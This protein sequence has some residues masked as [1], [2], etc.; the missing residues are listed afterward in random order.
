MVEHLVC[1]YNA[2][3]A[4]YV[5]LQRQTRCQQENKRC[6]ETTHKQDFWKPWGIITDWGLNLLTSQFLHHDS[7][8]TL[9]A[10]TY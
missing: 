8:K 9:R 5:K 3:I 2:G 4:V 1:L 7:R 10:T 6:L